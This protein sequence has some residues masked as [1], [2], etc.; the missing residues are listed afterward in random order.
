MASLCVAQASATLTLNC[1]RGPT[2]EIMFAYAQKDAPMH[3]DAF[4]VAGYVHYAR[5]ATNADKTDRVQP[6]SAPRCPPPYG[7]TTG[8]SAVRIASGCL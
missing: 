3:S 4:D 5:S 8:S 6:S 7:L 1:W 2:A